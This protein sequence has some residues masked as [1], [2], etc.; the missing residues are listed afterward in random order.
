MPKVAY[1][2]T[3]SGNNLYPEYI[4]NIFLITSDCDEG[5]CFSA[6]NPEDQKLVWSVEDRSGKLEQQ[7]T[8]INFYSFDKFTVLPMVN[9]LLVLDHFTG[10][11]LD[12][13]H[14]Q[15][16]VAS[17]LFG[18]GRYVYPVVTNRKQQNLS[19]LVYDLLKEQTDTLISQ[20]FP[21]NEL[22]VSVGPI[23]CP[24]DST[25][26]F[27]SVLRYRPSDNRTYNYLLKWHPNEGITDT[28]SLIGTN[29]MGYGATRPPLIDKLN[30]ISFWHLTNSIVAFNHNTNTV[31]W[32]K[33]ID[34]VSLASR[35]V[36]F[37]DKIIYPTEANFFLILNKDSGD[38]VDTIY[39]TPSFPG[40]IASTDD[41]LFFIGGVDGH[42]YGLGNSQENTDE[43]N[44]NLKNYTMSSY[45]N[46][47][48]QLFINKD[49]LV[50]NNGK[51]W[52]FSDL[53]PAD[54][55]NFHEVYLNTSKLS[56]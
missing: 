53:N 6:F 15:G 51:Q 1:V 16:N 28:I 47:K 54:L 11:Q 30:G 48:H 21:E 33:I 32:T 17:N 49:H 18:I 37:L 46:L 39:N 14:F 22:V 27:N 10:K 55:K 19:I 3:A 12:S 13:I 42:L 7:Y 34:Q 45:G 2:N 36:L 29:F 56:D 8:N 43:S 40:R 9:H 23:S 4:G 50:I 41:K 5:Y 52:I 20:S 35:P 24:V 25:A 38:I 44:F 31:A 26:L